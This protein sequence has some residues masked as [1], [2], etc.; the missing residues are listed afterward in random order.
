MPKTNKGGDKSG[1][2]SGSQPALETPAPVESGYWRVEILGMVAQGAVFFAAL[3]ISLVVGILLASYFDSP[4]GL[5][6]TTI[7]SG[8]GLLVGAGLSQ[9]LRD[10]MLMRALEHKSR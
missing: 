10:H 6:L 7:V 2:K 1:G 8:T 3:A 5:L 9:S 4:G